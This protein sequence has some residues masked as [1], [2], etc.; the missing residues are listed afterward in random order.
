V[1][2]I[3]NFQTFTWPLIWRT[4]SLRVWNVRNRRW[5]TFRSL[6]SRGSNPS[7]GMGVSLRIFTERCVGS[8]VSDGLITRPEESYR[9]CVSNSAWCRNCK[10][11]GDLS[12]S[13]T[14][15]PQQNKNCLLID[16]YW[17]TDSRPQKQTQR[18]KVKTRF[19]CGV[20]GYFSNVS[21]QDSTKQFKACG[22]LDYWGGE[23][24]VLPWRWTQQLPPKRW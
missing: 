14:V 18:R 12:Q 15:A 19:T 5:P 22:L 24:I 16:M 17:V 11:S 6:G 13:W 7:Q 3:W 21:L 1:K 10:K 8:G 23:K 20:S 2:W 4:I 9:L